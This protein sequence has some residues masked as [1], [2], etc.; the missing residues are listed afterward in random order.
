MKV[1]NMLGVFFHYCYKLKMSVA[2]KKNCGCVAYR[3]QD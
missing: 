2:I 3:K 1:T